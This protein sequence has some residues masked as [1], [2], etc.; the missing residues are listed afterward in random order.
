[1]YESVDVSRTTGSY[2]SSGQLFV[3][4]ADISGVLAS[5]GVIV[6]RRE[7]HAASKVALRGRPCTTTAVR[8][9]DIC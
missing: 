3:F 5:L 7:L 2:L 1:M 9:S 6:R 8:V 4:V